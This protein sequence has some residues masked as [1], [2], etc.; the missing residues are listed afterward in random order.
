MNRSARLAA[1]AVL[2]ALALTGCESVLPDVADWI[3]DSE[4]LARRFDQRLG[5]LAQ[6]VEEDNCG[7][8]LDSEESAFAMC[9]WVASRGKSAPEKFEAAEWY[10]FDRLCEG[11]EGVLELPPAEAIARIEGLRAET[12]RISEGIRR[13]IEPREREEEERDRD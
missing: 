13:D 12:D 10:R 5:D 3:A 2:A 6:C 4:T 1:V 7:A 9:S 11:L 8:D